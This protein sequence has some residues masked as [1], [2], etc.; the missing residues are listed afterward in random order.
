MLNQSEKAYCLALQSLR[1]HEYDQALNFFNS[2]A[3]FFKDNR[4][5]NILRETTAL[6]M[7]IKREIATLERQPRGVEDPLFNGEVLEDA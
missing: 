2:A 4:E 3:D 7:E 1:A 6:L 5:F